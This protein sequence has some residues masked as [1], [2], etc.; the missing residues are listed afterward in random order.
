MANY[1]HNVLFCGGNSSGL[2][3]SPHIQAAIERIKVGNLFISTR[4]FVDI[5]NKIVKK[6]LNKN[7]LEEKFG[8]YSFFE[9][10][11]CIALVYFWK[12]N[13]NTSFWRRELAVRMIRRTLQKKPSVSIDYEYRF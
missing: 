7:N 13:A 6:S 3:T 8:Q 12:K 4:D 2:F 11:L 5:Y 10:I 1:V 9:I